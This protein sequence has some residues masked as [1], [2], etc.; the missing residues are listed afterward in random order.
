MNGGTRFPRTLSLEHACTRHA[1]GIVLDVSMTPEAQLHPRD[2]FP[3]RERERERR[4]PLLSGPG[5][6][7]WILSFTEYIP[8]SRSL[9]IFFAALEKD[10]PR[11]ARTKATP[12]PY[13]TFRC[14]GL[15]SLQ[16][17]EIHGVYQGPLYRYPLSVLALSLIFP[18]ITV[19]YLHISIE[20]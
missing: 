11:R 6:L 16:S 12:L 15:S 10:E 9:H 13:R 4:V 18:P 5:V 17:R 14:S 19:N 1:R 7:S 2:S 20:Q 3:R 8:G